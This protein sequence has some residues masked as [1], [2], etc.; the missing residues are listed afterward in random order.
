FTQYA[1]TVQ[2]L[3]TGGNEAHLA[4]W[5][6]WEP[7][8]RLSALAVLGGLTLF[9]IRSR[10]E[11][12]GR[13]TYVIDPD[14]N[15]RRLLAWY[16]TLALQTTGTIQRGSLPVYLGTILIVLVAGAAWPVLG[17]RIWEMPTPERR[18]WDTPVQLIPAIIMVVTALTAVFVRRRLYSV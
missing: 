7:H 16:E 15:C 2:E 8:L 11:D 18:L 12:S 1:D 4:Q 5:H 14:R 17:G 10:P 3:G 6:G 9:S 13:A